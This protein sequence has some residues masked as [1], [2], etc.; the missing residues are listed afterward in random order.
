MTKPQRAMHTLD[1]DVPAKTITIRNRAWET[2]R[3]EIVVTARKQKS[4]YGDDLEIFKEDGTWIGTVGSYTG[5][6]DRPAGRLRI[7]G[8]SRKL[9]HNTGTYEGARAMYGQYSRA[10]A[11]RWLLNR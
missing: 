1:E 5:T 9:W 3:P 7:V 8:K 4:V 10:D 11:I 6:L 2:G